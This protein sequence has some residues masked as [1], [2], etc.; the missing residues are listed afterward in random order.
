MHRYPKVKQ[1]MPE[2]IVPSADGPAISYSMTV[3]LRTRDAGG[4]ESSQVVPPVLS[5]SV[6]PTDNRRSDHSAVPIIHKRCQIS[7][8][9]SAS[10]PARSRRRSAAAR[11]RHGFA[12][13]LRIDMEKFT[14]V[15][16]ARRR[17]RGRRARRRVQLQRE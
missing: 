14:L 2:H 1:L 8:P 10:A 5:K 11:P 17:L 3:S 7:G 16:R 9:V 13:I 6:Q 4:R 15:R 12:P